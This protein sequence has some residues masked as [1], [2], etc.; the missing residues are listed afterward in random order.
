MFDV[1][2][3]SKFSNSGPSFSGE[4]ISNMFTINSV[5]ANLVLERL[6]WQKLQMVVSSFR[7]L[8]RIN[9]I[10]F[11]FMFIIL[12]LVADLLRFYFA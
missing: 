7:V 11:N 1:L 5:M 2:W 10:I 8:S 9:V 3:Q 12:V 6:K 4:K